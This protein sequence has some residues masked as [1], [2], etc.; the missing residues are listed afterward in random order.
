MAVEAGPVLN[1]VAVT[2][3]CLGECSQVQCWKQGFNGI[4][5][6]AARLDRLGFSKICNREANMKKLT[7]RIALVVLP[8][9]MAGCSSMNTGS[10]S[11]KTSAT[12]SAGG[13]NAQNANSQLEHCDASLGTLAVVED[14]SSGWSR[15]LSR[16]ANLGPTTPV[17]RLLVQQSNCFVVVERGKAMSKLAQERALE[18]SG[19][20]RTDSNFGKGQMVAADFTLSPS[21]TF[22]NNNSGGMGGSLRGLIPGVGGKVAGAV[23]GNTK[24]KEASTMLTLVDN[25]SGVQLAAAEGSAS[26]VDFGSLGSVFGRA[27]GASL[28]GYSNTAEGKVIVSAFTDSYNNLVRAVRNYKPQDVKGGLGKGGHLKVN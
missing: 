4:R 2:M 20:L 7:K 11:A 26:N 1:L 8:I 24:F 18:K 25:R 12:G 6:Q 5:C 21:V 14:T 9:F 13:D 15:T 10:S 27:G 19:D 28:G 23:A 22:S 17:L 16:E 3:R